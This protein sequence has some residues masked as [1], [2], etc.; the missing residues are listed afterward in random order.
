MW[1]R[2]RGHHPSQLGIA[3]ATWTIVLRLAWQLLWIA[4][5][6]V[7][8]GAVYAWLEPRTPNFAD[9]L[10]LAFSTAS[11][12]GYHEVAPSTPASKLFSVVVVLLGF[13]TLSLVTAAI[14]AAFVGSQER[15]IEHEIMRDLHR[16]IAAVRADFAALR[17]ELR[18][19]APG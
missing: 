3:S 1:N 6:L 13:V 10:W 17:A 19:D 7:G 16:E 9:G 8:C 11:T 18:R 12:I 4:I 15:R 5:L 14:A 2:Q